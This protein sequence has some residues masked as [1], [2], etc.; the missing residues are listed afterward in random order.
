[1]VQ[2]LEHWQ[3]R[4]CTPVG[5]TAS[6]KHRQS[7]L[8]QTVTELSHETRFPYACFADDP[9]HLAPPGLGLSK[10]RVQHRHHPLP[11]DEWAQHTSQRRVAWWTLRTSCVERVSKHRRGLF[12]QWDRPDCRTGEPALE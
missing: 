11:P 5:T 12:L 9:H 6:E 2:Q 3:V 10:Q 8:L 1:M 4:R 7:S